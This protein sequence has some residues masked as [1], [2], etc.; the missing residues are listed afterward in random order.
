MTHI[1]MP[2]R[3][4]GQYLGR[5]LSRHL[6]RDEGGAIA[7]MFALMLA[8]LFGM[9]ALAMDLGKVWNLE[10]ELQHAA[11]A[12]ALAG[13]TQLDGTDGARVRAIQAAISEI[14]NNTQRFAND[15]VDADSSGA[16]DGVDIEFDTDIT[17]DGGSDKANNRD[18]KF[19][20]VLP[21]DP[22]NESTSD[23]DA[24]FIECNV[25]PRTA[26]F[27]FAAVVGA[28]TSASPS[29]RAVAGWASLYCDSPP[30]MMCNPDED[31]GGDP[32]ALFDLYASCPDYGD[33]PSCVGRG[34]TMKARA[35]APEP[36]DFGYLAIET[37][38][39]DGTIQT[40][41]GVPNLLEA[42]ASVEFANICTGNQVT[43]EPGNMAALDQAINQR[44]D[45]YP[46]LATALIANRQPA[47][48]V[49]RGLMK[50]ASFDPP[51]GKCKF[52]PQTPASPGDWE[53]AYD[54][55]GDRRY[56]RGP[57]MHTQRADF[58]PGDPAHGLDHV[59]DLVS[60]GE[61]DPPIWA[62]AY[63]K[64][65]CNYLPVNTS[66]GVY[67]PVTGNPAGCLF[68]VPPGNPGVP[69]GEQIG[70]G[71][72]DIQ[73]YLDV[74]HPGMIEADVVTPCVADPDDPMCADKPNSLD[75]VIPRDGR[76]SRW[77][78][79]NWEKRYDAL[80]DSYP[81]MAFEEEP[82][83]YRAPDVFPTDY[84]LP[85]APAGAN[86]PDRRIIVMAVVNCA[87]MGGGRRTV[88]R[89]EPHGNVAVFLTEPMG[90]TLPDTLYGELVDPRG[91]GIGDVDT[92]PTLIRERIVLIE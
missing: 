63:P 26:T 49:G 2:A 39:E 29:A 12:C 24:R 43:T 35:G 36:G 81:N 74:Y 52:S 9:M 78:L 92:N 87:A 50:K 86:T 27:A 21:I 13:V 79:Y 70:A 77:E 58:F 37:I 82:L 3:A 67:G 47:P 32:D 22:A 7:V 73:V 34:I 76:I 25:F 84:T 80:T 31:P 42:L 8:A 54:G 71:Q 41:T 90:L 48:N 85:E 30:M 11:D 62:M 66:Q 10:T 23:A 75:P 61:M 57:G 56:Y 6:A 40:V 15:S 83:C 4:P 68:K 33:G 19:Y 89:T 65:A 45:L 14:A 46:D 18:I 59:P 16:P 5:S 60:M 69:E 1:R 51:N 55:G 88:P 91:L 53:R 44:F 38:L 72:W 64:D 17:I 20:L 28:V